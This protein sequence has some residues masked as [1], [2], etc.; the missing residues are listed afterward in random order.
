MYKY[1]ERICYL[2]GSP[3]EIGFLMGKTLGPKLEANIERYIRER[4]PRDVSLDIERWRLGALPWLHALPMRFQ[5]EFAG[6]ARGSGL[7]LQRLAE[8]ASLEGFLSGRCS[9][10]IVAIG[11]QVWVA[12]NNDIFAPGM[13]GY[14]TIRE[15]TGRIP[16]ISFG[17][18]G[19]VFTPTGINRERLWLHYNYLPAHDAPDGEKP[20]W[21]C[22][23]LMVEALETCRTLHDLEDL[24]EH[25]QR[26]GAMLLFAVDGKTNAYALYEC[27]CTDFYKREPAHGWLVGTNHY[28]VHPK[29]RPECDSDVLSSTNRYTRMEELVGNLLSL[30]G[31]ASP[32]EALIRVL[33]DDGIER[34]NGDA[35]TA[36]SNVACPSAKE[37]WY[38]FGGYPS[39]SHGN[40]QR[41][42]WPW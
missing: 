37:I 2:K 1:T 7:P 30:P 9:G 15:V 28:C 29:A 33:S 8:W 4:V 31:S 27:G 22:Y 5:D 41:L 32:V 24:L 40:W 34:R 20:C 42:D 18:E 26:D 25:T 19:D 6:L 36:Y 11:R 21:P 39:A 17:M 14:V 10:A 23:V 35:V 3:F 12:R 13:W 16:A 38:T